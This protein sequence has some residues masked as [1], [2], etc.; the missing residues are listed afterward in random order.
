MIDKFPVPVTW[1]D[2]LADH[3][4]RPA[5]ALRRAGLP[6][7]LFAR[8]RPTL[9]ATDFR[10]LWDAM[11][12]LLDSETPALFLTFDDMPLTL[13]AACSASL[14]DAF[15]RV[16]AYNTMTGS[17]PIKMHQTLGGL[18]VTVPSVPELPDEFILATLATLVRLARVGL[19]QDV[20]PVAVEMRAPPRTGDCRAFFGRVLRPGPFDR[21]VFTS[22]LATRRFDAPAP[23]HFAQ[24]EPELRPR[25][26]ELAPAATT[27]KRV[28]SALMEALPAGTPD[29]GSV[30]ERLGISTRSLQRRL[31]G[32][33]TSFNET[34]KSLRA[35]LS[36]HYLDNTSL[37]GSQIAFLLGFD[38]PNSFIRA[39]R[40]WTGTTP[41]NMRR[42][43]SEKR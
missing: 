41:E 10:S 22:E 21:V 15:G 25:L 1:A 5:N 14:P 8:L 9:N 23:S 34:L 18:E 31:R 35:R 28:T 40:D 32:D 30:A 43:L 16:A 37:S 24:F 11:A 38:D 42:K 27:R 2:L 33:G 17:F 7:D 39:F 36:K 20:R 12:D 13:A 4:I 3:Q 6:E 29:V 19:G 26:D